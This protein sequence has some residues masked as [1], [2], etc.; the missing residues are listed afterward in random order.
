MDAVVREMVVADATRAEPARQSVCGDEVRIERTQ[1][2]SLALLAARVR[3]EREAA[4]RAVA[5][6]TR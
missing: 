4:A 6:G 2:A 5:G 1:A 3:A